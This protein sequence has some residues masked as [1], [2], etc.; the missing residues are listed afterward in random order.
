MTKTILR[1]ALA[2]IG[3][4]AAEPAGA[5]TAWDFTFVGIDGADMALSHFAGKAVLVVNTASQC[6][7]TPQ[8]KALEDL[9]RTYRDRGLVVLGVPSNDFG[10]QEPGGAAEIKQFCETNFGID[11][12]MTEKVTVAGEAAHPFYRWAAREMGPL[13]VPRW[14]FHKYLIAADGRLVDWF[15]SITAPDSARLIKAVEANLPR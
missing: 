1:T 14:N 2:A 13:A 3:L 7:F 10:G 12:P 6:G 15:S 5:S 11:F 9:Y 8:Y 4:L